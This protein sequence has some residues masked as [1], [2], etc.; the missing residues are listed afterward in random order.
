MHNPSN[1]AGSQET[2]NSTLATASPHSV[3]PSLA[4][5]PD[6]LPPLAAPARWCLGL[7]RRVARPWRTSLIERRATAVE[8]ALAWLLAHDRGA[9]LPQQE[10]DPDPCPST[11][12][13]ACQVLGPAAG[14]SRLARWQRTADKKTAPADCLHSG[15][16][17]FRQQRADGAVAPRRGQ[18]A[19]LVDT[20]HLVQ[21]I[22][23]E[24]AAEFS[25]S[26]DNSLAA[27]DLPQHLP[28]QDGRWQA[29]AAALARL[30]P[31][32]RVLDVGAGSGRFLRA[33]RE[34]FPQFELAA[35]EPASRW[36][37]LWPEGVPAVEGDLWH[38]ASAPARFDA[39][40]AVESLEHALW[41][42]RAVTEL[43]RVVRP[44]GVVL[45]IDKD[46]QHQPLSR[47]ATW[48]RWFHPAEVTAWLA[49]WCEAI[50]A[51]PIAHGNAARV[52][53]LFWCWQAVRRPDT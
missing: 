29:T 18:P 43:C 27:L 50:S 45:V 10:G 41:P 24:V 4:A 1:S 26:A 13:L 9:G 37:A 11:T 32:G 40:L 3:A 39:A 33:L 49:P 42:S 44:G 22:R 23:A 51:R 8:R 52:S 36:R 28:A 5:P 6:D 12:Q 16:W 34:H 20:L 14:A 38:L 48:E 30:P 2:A 21:A 17:W 47:T 53:G 7:A 35:V 19:R 15:A 31:R 46:R 25:C